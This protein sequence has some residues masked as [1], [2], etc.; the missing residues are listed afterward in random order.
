MYNSLAYLLRSAIGEARQD[1][2]GKHENFLAYLSNHSGFFWSDT[3]R[4]FGEIL[5]L[6]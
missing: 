6:F 2:S 1:A 4:L 5:G 3:M